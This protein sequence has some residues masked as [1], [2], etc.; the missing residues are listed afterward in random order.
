MNFQRFLGKISACYR[1]LDSKVQPSYSQSGE[2]MVMR[3]LVYNVLGL[4]LPT[5]LD[6]GTNHPYIGNNTFYFYSRGSRG[7]CIEPDEQFAPLIRKYRKHDIHLKAG[8]AAG[9]GGNAVMY[10]F[11]G[12]LSSW[13]TFS[14]EEAMVRQQEAGVAFTEVEKVA[15][16]NINEV[17][18]K[19]F[20][21]HPN[22]LS[23]DVEGLDLDILQSLDFSRYRPEVI[24]IE[25]ITFSVSNEEEKIAAIPELLTSKGYVAYADTHI[26]T[27]FCRADVLKTKHP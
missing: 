5:Y 6:I 9:D 22:I 24:C 25:T 20:S 7:V 15:L 19:Y 8:V 21:P 13:N 1:V 17:M 16:V 4:P 27:I 14:K 26:N 18:A 11:P 10:A 12:E 23:L 2:D 3:Y